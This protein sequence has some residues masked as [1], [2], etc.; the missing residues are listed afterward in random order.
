MD[1]LLVEKKYESTDNNSHKN[2]ILSLIRK[3]LP[4]YLTKKFLNILPKRVA[5]NPTKLW[6]ESIT[7]HKSF[8]LLNVLNNRIFS[9]SEQIKSLQILCSN[10]LEF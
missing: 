4:Q 7:T 10:I 1:Q 2:E 9:L 8:D 3:E 5:T 6:P